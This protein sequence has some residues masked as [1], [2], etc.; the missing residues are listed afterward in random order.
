MRSWQSGLY[1][2]GSHVQGLHKYPNGTVKPGTGKCDDLSS[3]VYTYNQ[4]VIM[5][6]SRG[7]WLAT[8]ARSYLEEG[9]VLVESVIRATGC[10][11]RASCGEA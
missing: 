3:M 1:Q 9:H 10:Q 6:A 2:D 7:L 8:G 11:T 5:S 4:S